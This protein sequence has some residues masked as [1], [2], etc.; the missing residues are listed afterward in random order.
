[1]ENI[2]PLAGKTLVVTPAPLAG[3]TE[4]DWKA[5]SSLLETPLYRIR[6][7]RTG[8]I[9]SIHDHAL[10]RELLS[11]DGRGN[12][13]QTFV[14]KP[15]E[16]EAW[17]I[18]E[19]C[20]GRKTDLF[21][22]NS[23]RTLAHGPLCA[24]VEF[25][26]KSANGSSITQHLVT[27]HASR[28]IDFRTRVHWKERQILL[29]AAFA[30]NASPGSAT[31]EIP[32]GT[33]QRSAKPRTP[34]EK[35]Q[36]EVPAQQWADVSDAKFG[37]SLLNDSKYGYDARDGVL[38]LTLLRSPHEPHETEPHKHTGDRITDQGEHLFTYAL[39]PH[40]GDWKTAETARRAREL[41]VPLVIREGLSSTPL[42]SLL[43]PL[44]PALFLDAVKRAEEGEEIVLRLHEGHGSTTRAQVQVGFTVDQ[45]WECDL[46]ER[47]VKKLKPVRSRIQL[48]FTPYEIKTLRLKVRPRPLK[49]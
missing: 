14:D 43:G 2:P 17:D 27:Y 33:L 46:L 10:R 15:K 42:P 9:T 20:L 19:E 47:A 35:A 49:P 12:V 38:R 16:W 8:R 21:S 5:S 36:F 29:K 40:A 26:W 39:L 3:P 7:D 37:L 1:V 30:L 31:Y 18:D 23:T 13:L 22:L 44:P 11:R 28:R 34:E 25:V 45:A 41:N 48:R 24:I 6:F 4:G 32:F